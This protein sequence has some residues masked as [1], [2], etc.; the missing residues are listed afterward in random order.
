LNHVPA[1]GNVAGSGIAAE[2]AKAAEKAGLGH[3][4]HDKS[5]ATSAGP[6]SSSSGLTHVPTGGSAAQSGVAAE[7]AR[8]AQKHGLGHAEGETGG[9]VDGVK[10]IAP[11]VVEATSGPAGGVAG[12]SDSDLAKPEGLSS[13]G[14]SSTRAPLPASTGDAPLAPE[15][16]HHAEG[17]GLFG[18]LGGLGAAAI[19]AATAAATN[20]AHM[21]TDD[22]SATA[23]TSPATPKK[24]NPSAALAAIASNSPTA[25]I[26]REF[27]AVDL[28]HTKQEVVNV[29]ERFGG[30]LAGGLAGLGN[31]AG[32]DAQRVAAHTGGLAPATPSGSVANTPAVGGGPSSFVP[33]S[34]LTGTMNNAAGSVGSSATVR[35]G[36][37]QG[38]SSG[39]APATSHAT[40]GS[41]SVPGLDITETASSLPRDTPSVPGLSVNGSTPAGEATKSATSATEKSASSSSAVPGLNIEKRASTSTGAVAA[42]PGLSVNGSSPSGSS[43]HKPTPIHEDKTTGT[44][45]AVGKDDNASSS[46][47]RALGQ[48]APSAAHVAPTEGLPASSSPAAT[49]V[50]S[51]SKK[52]T[53]ALGM[54]QPQQAPVTPKKS[55]AE[56]SNAATP[57]TDGYKTAPS[58]PASQAGT[59]ADRKRKSSIFKK[60][61]GAFSSPA[62]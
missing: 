61:K 38:V 8:E 30:A 35:E 4:E 47:G 27:A 7:A 33:T 48:D 36:S 1:G 12:M 52:D 56:A 43:T 22:H 16:A 20:V 18:V 26:S 44:K 9:S 34:G 25:M 21:V 13:T 51:V 17:K 29:V 2:A 19:G 15:S 3:D 54:G 11:G 6:A 14:S 50:N 57:A 55:T 49:P 10:K 62:K 59:P 32:T 60:I 45:P 39:A 24:D 23:T 28:S 31:M 42:V 58:T 41:S 46:V 5:A 40:S 53:S 37:S